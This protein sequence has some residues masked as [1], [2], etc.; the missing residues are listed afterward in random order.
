MK[1]YAIKVISLTLT[2]LV[3]ASRGSTAPDNFEPPPVF[4]ATNILPESLRIGPNHKV[5]EKVPVQRFGYQFTLSTNRGE[6]GVWGKDTLKIKVSELAAIEK[7]SEI[8]QTRAFAKSIS[9][10]AKDPVM[11]AWNVASRPVSTIKGLPGGAGRYLKGA[12]YKARKTTRVIAKSL[13]NMGRPQEGRDPSQ[14]TLTQQAA[15]ATRDASKGHLGFNKA[16]RRWAKRLKVD[17]YLD[18]PEL[19]KGLDRIAWATALG[20]FAAD[21]TL[22]SYAPLSY[23]NKVQDAVWETPPI[24]LERQNDERLKN[25]GIEEK[26]IQEFHEHASY[27]ITSKTAIS[28]A[29]ASM[30]GVQGRTQIIEVVLGASDRFEAV[31]MLK[32]CAILSNHH[33]LDTPL[34]RIEIKRGM[35]TAID[36]DDTLVFPVAIEYLHWT[37]LALEIAEDKV[38]ENGR[39]ELWITGD[40]SP[41]ARNQLTELGWE[42]Q[43]NC[44][45]RF[46]AQE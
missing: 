1:L 21:Y 6:I 11:K 34:D 16:K 27:S 22:P 33:E 7:L 13:S 35:I 17:P 8:S 3:I 46:L 32:I 29:I 45:E 40:V 20:S 23:S 2:V 42:T 43:E 24:E 18:N 39:R 28:L 37:P 4:E 5:N 41:H 30:D 19:Q 44:F 25:A 10:A 15:K 26:L 9:A 31:M 38:F 36:Q 12:F 14:E